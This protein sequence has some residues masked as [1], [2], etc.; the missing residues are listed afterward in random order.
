LVKSVRIT[1]EAASRSLE[2]FWV[3]SRDFGVGS[4]DSVKPHGSRA[5]QLGLQG[6]QARKP[7]SLARDWKFGS[8][9]LQQLDKA[10]HRELT[11]SKTVVRID[12][13]I[14]LFSLFF[15]SQHSYL[16]WDRPG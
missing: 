4:R 12:K 1:A 2:M 10:K 8:S 16:W 13:N 5:V 7:C 3:G 11:W 6:S 9:F 14:F 15:F